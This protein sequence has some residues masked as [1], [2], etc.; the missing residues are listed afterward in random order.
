MPGE[1][2]ITTARSASAG[3]RARSA[4]SWALIASIVAMMLAPGWRLTMSSTAGR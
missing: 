1:R 2:S 4:G 3:S